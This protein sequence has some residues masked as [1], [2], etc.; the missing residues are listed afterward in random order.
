MN[1]PSEWKNGTRLALVTGT[2]SAMIILGW[3]LVPGD[4]APNWYSIPAGISLP[5]L[6]LATFWGILPAIMDKWLFKRME[7]HMDWLDRPH[8]ET[9]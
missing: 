3:Q 9:Q 1:H 8:K 6:L 2:L 7:Q 5:F 4:P